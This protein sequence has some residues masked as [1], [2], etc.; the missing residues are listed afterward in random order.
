M[1]DVNTS[2]TAEEGAHSPSRL[3]CMI[4]LVCIISRPV[5]RNRLICIINIIMQDE[6]AFHLCHTHCKYY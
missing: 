4:R 3:V 2:R 5:W 1:G 6:K